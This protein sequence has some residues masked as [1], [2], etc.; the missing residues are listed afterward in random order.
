MWHDS[1]QQRSLI[2]AI[3]ATAAMLVLPAGVFQTIECF[4]RLG[5]FRLAAPWAPH[6]R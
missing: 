1:E 5:L 3:V 4:W 6:A 2:V